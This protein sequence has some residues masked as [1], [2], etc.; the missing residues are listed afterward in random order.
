MRSY[1]AAF[2]LLALASGTALAAPMSPD[3][4][5]DVA[6]P[7]SPVPGTPDVN[8][9]DMTSFASLP[10]VDYDDLDVEDMAKGNKY[11]EYEAWLQHQKDGR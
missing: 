1:T 11:K 8:G 9:N 3:L 6:L 7:S 5:R 2:G 10:K 4:G